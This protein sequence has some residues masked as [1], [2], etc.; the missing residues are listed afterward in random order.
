MSGINGRRGPWTCEG[1]MSHCRGIPRHGGRSGWLGGG[2][3]FIEAGGGGLDRGLEG[4]PRKGLTFEMQIK[5]TS[6]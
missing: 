3:S 5:K 4:R 2:N 1:P 6:N